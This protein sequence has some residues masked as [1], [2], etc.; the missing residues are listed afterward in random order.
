M[1]EHPRDALA[2]IERVAQVKAQLKPVVA[3][4]GIFWVSK[5]EF[6]R[7]F[8]SI[9]VSASDMSDFVERADGNYTRAKRSIT[10]ADAAGPGGA[11]GGGG[12]LRVP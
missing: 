7:Y 5:E 9:Y 1:R 11:A 8:P 10:S 4:D 12:G 2:A 6:F 3:D